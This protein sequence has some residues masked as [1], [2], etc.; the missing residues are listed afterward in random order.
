MYRLETLLE[1][2]IDTQF[3]LFEIYVLRNTFTFKDELLPYLALPHHVREL[4]TP[5]SP[6]P[7]TDASPARLRSTS[8]PLSAT[9]TSPPSTRTR[10][11]S[12]RTRPSC[13]P[14]ANSPPRSCSSR[15][16]S[17]ARGRRQ[18]WWGTSSRRVRSCLPLVRSR[19]LAGRTAVIRGMKRARSRNR[20]ADFVTL[21]GAQANSTHRPHLP[22]PPTSSPR[23]SPRSNP[24]SPNSSRRPRPLP[25]PPRPH[26]EQGAR[27]SPPG[28]Q[29]AASS[30]TGRRRQR[31]RRLP[32]PVALAGGEQR[33]R[34]SRG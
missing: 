28:R 13:K 30:S 29:A 3:D 25:S 22:R 20:V 27:A 6:G 32:S 14:S 4:C 24:A 16:R 8:T 9:P 12:Q 2:A 33:T 19:V 5:S 26:P 23:S 18:S 11:S 1:D 7:L 21:L 31:P 10:P 15:P 34:R 17:P